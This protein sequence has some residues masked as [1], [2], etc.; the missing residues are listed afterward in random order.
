LTVGLIY[1]LGRGDRYL[2]IEREWMLNLPRLLQLQAYTPMNLFDSVLTRMPEESKAS[3][4]AEE[5]KKA[6]SNRFDYSATGILSRPT[7]IPTDRIPLLR[8]GK[9]CNM[10]VVRIQTLLLQIMLAYN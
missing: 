5:S 4:Q 10:F 7:P 6:V 9:K 1:R 8:D 3:K 2:E